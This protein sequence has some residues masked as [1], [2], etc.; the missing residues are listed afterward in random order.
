MKLARC[1]RLVCGTVLAMAAV[2]ISAPSQAQP[3]SAA[4][5]RRITQ[6]VSNASRITLHGT[7]SPL[8]NARNDTGPASPSLWLDHV[9][10]VL[11]KSPS[12]QADLDAF[13]K[14]LQ[15]PG[16][17]NYHK[18]LTPDQFGQKFGPNPQDISSIEDWVSS[19]GF[20]VKQVNPGNGSLVISG[21]V[22][23]LDQAFHTSI[24]RYLVGG[25]YYYANALDPQI[26]AALAPVLAG[27]VSLNNFPA[28]RLSRYLGK[29]GYDPATGQSTPQW[30]TSSNSSPLGYYLAVSPGDF[31]AQYD[32]NPLYQAGTNGS[33]QT[34]A[35]VNDSNININ[36]VNN[37]RSL[38]G[39]P[40]NPPQVIVTGSDPGIDGI[41]NPDGA[42]FDSI[43]AYLDVEWAGAVAPNAKVDLV[44]AG[45]TAVQNGLIL[46]AEHAV[47]S[48]I[49][50][51]ISVSFGACEAALGSSNQFLNSLWQQAA[52]QGIT[53][54]VASG[55]SGSAG[56]APSTSS[57]QQVCDSSD[58]ATAQFGLAVNGYA[59]TPY[60]VAVGG[61][62]FYYSSYQ[63]SSALP[64]QIQSYWNT[65][66]TSAP[67][68]S[69]KG[70]VPEQPWNDTSL[71]LNIFQSQSPVG[72][73]GGGG[74][75]S[76][77][78]MPTLDSNGDVVT[79]APY[80][81]P[82]WQTGPGVPSNNARYIPDVSL[83]AADGMND[84]YYPICAA[85]GDCQPG[86]SPVQISGVGGT[87]GAAP[88]M[89]GIMALVD[90]KYGPQGQADF[91]LYP[92]A[93][94]HASAFHDVTVGTNA[95]P[96]TGSTDCSG[97]KLTGFSATPG[98]DPATGLGTIDANELVSNWNSIRFTSTS[99]TLSVSPS[100]FTHGASVTLQVGVSGSGGTP[101]GNVAIMTDS[102]TVDQQGI[103][104]LALSNGQASGSINFLPGGTY[105]VWAQYAGDGKFGASTSSKV[106]ITVNPESSNIIF[107]AVT[108]SQSG[109]SS[110]SG[111]SVPY[112]TQIILDGEVVPSSFYKNC[113]QGQSSSSA[114]QNASFGSATGTVVFSDGST[115][116]NSALINTEGDAEYT[117][118]A[119]PVG[120]HSVSAKYSGDPSYGAS[121]A[122][123]I[124]FTIVQATPTVTV[125]TNTTQ[126]SSSNHGGPLG[127]FWSTGGGI[128]V[129]CAFFF[130]I[131]RRRKWQKLFALAVVA[132]LAFGC[133]G[134]GG[135]GGGGGGTGGGG[136][137]TPPVN[138]PTSGSIAS[139][140]T[141]VLTAVVDSNGVGLPPS[142]T[143]TFK[144]G[145]SSLGTAN[146]VASTNPNSGSV[147]SVATL[148]IPAPAAGTLNITGSYGGDSNYTSANSSAVPVTVGTAS[149]LVPSSVKATVTPQSATTSPA[150]A[151]TLNVT[152]TGQSGHGAPTGT[153]DVLA[154]GYST[155]SVSLK[156]GAGDSSTLSAPFAPFN[157]QNLSQGA[158]VITFQYLGDGTYQPSSTT[159]TLNNPLADFSMAA[160]NQVLS[161][162]P[163]GTG[164]ATIDFGAI[165]G[166]N[167]AVSLQCAATA[168]YTCSV[169]P[170]SVTVGGNPV[171][172][173]VAVS[174]SAP[175]SGTASV[176]VTG[177]SG[178][179]M[180]NVTVMLK[181]PPP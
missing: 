106:R 104:S 162:S 171:S 103:T 17:A 15:T 73:V 124:S 101:T 99:A 177:T 155:S 66:P 105:N 165:N 60:D 91:V 118:G 172:A 122:G 16:S 45:D 74:G 32:L 25:Q 4:A 143:V 82:S 166:F 135:S 61:T 50:P 81:K 75:A 29:A 112:G 57:M 79:C 36:F 46:A 110:V 129:G 90:Q 20:T 130:G 31:A 41:N 85:D 133:G 1:F 100:S 123:A 35:I 88:A 180:H 51:V 119:L 92:L 154:P 55:D 52:A 13:L 53:V 98:Y 71:G 33:G 97:G 139:G 146:L 137:G 5:A 148:S 21:S 84:S 40:S 18:W 174:A 157:S 142:G 116:L 9:Q 141:L 96:C 109:F 78:G 108:S 163:G 134:G 63:N 42:N 37:F 62:D 181:L 173:S 8:A 64:S 159:V 127:W 169:S 149:T 87:S 86:A 144:N 68:V 160:T 23:Q 167:S 14:E 170:G 175:A 179:I 95:M 131:P 93:Q 7:V 6:P 47:F 70:Y 83:F 54:L 72:L 102:S 28:H 59:S 178:A 43:E 168:G 111:S 161:I 67:Q 115:T 10:L 3:V 145:S 12:Q 49:A 153:V 151:I 94:Q 44:I 34:I 150:S 120:N 22:G 30:T 80:P 19:Q 176:V 65:S 121:N 24:H 136:G 140:Q 156:A 27:F 89:A 125:T 77:C 158:T 128:V 76:T 26:P 39:L 152:V 107:N 48:N 147:T 138:P 113:N 69:I 164:N 114:C 38:F 126:A 11:R 117:T 132:V 2:I 58:S 56:T